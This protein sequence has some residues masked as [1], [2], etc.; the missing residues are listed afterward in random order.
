MTRLSTLTLICTV[1]LASFFA[2][3]Q[4]QAEDSREYTMQTIELSED[5]R[6]EGN[7]LYISVHSDRYRDAGIR[8]KLKLVQVDST[9]LAVKSE[10]DTERRDENRI[11][12]FRDQ[13]TFFVGLDSGSAT[14]WTVV[15]PK[16]LSIAY[17]VQARFENFCEAY[18]EGYLYDRS[19][20][21]CFRTGT[22]GCSNPFEF[23]TEAACRQ[24]NLLD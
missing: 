10:P 1:S 9:F 8:N 14:T 16:E 21:T 15:Y 7:T 13:A 20:D 5:D 18:W 23:T 6:R 11:R 24:G 3:L 4:A 17:E 2:A 22:S 12:T 19:K